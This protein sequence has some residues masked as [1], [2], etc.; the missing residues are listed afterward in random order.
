MYSVYLNYQV[1]LYKGCNPI[2]CSNYA[3][4]FSVLP[5][6]LCTLLLVNP[7]CGNT[8]LFQKEQPVSN[9][10][11]VQR[12]MT[13]RIDTMSNDV[14]KLKGISYHRATRLLLPTVRSVLN[15]LF[16]YLSFV[17]VCLHSADLS[18]RKYV[19]RQ[20]R[21]CFPQLSVCVGYTDLVIFCKQ[22]L[23]SS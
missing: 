14:Y 17:Y 21:I 8:P 2:C 3:M 23:R 22:C 18:E 13:A 5:V 15:L 4:Y 19:E 10:Y 6:C 16:C 20:T 7:F 9:S 1:Y 12:F 11:G